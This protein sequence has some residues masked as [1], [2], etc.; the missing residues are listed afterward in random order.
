[1]VSISDRA[2][3]IPD[4]K[5][6][7]QDL[8]LD[9]TSTVEV[10]ESFGSHPDFDQVA[11]IYKEHNGIGRVLTQAVQQGL[12]TGPVAN[13][14]CKPLTENFFACVNTTFNNFVLPMVAECTRALITSKLPG[15]ID[16]L[17]KI[18]KGIRLEQ[19]NS[20]MSDSAHLPFLIKLNELCKGVV[21]WENRRLGALQ[22]L[23]VIT[24]D[25]HGISAGTTFFQEPENCPHNL[26]E[27]GE[28]IK[29]YAAVVRTLEQQA[30]EIVCDF[31]ARAAPKRN[32]AVAKDLNI[33]AG[34]KGEPDAS[35]AKVFSDAILDYL[36][37]DSVLNWP[38]IFVHCTLHT[39]VL[40]EGRLVTPPSKE[41]EH[42]GNMI[43]GYQIKDYQLR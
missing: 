12:I 14:L 2:S 30:V 28:S 8:A 19:P 26:K 33:P 32:I 39:L 5:L 42:Y 35:I 27:V 9:L 43:K 37:Q 16:S 22:G 38:L 17:E 6:S 18:I 23:T 7:A 10:K 25:A 24:E 31:C 40:E 21:V 3:E 20:S 41:I 13:Q 34:L 4:W 29:E 1:M 15:H 11:L 36:I